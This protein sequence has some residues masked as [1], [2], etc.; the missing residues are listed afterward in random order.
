MIYASIVIYKHS[1]EELEPTLNS[2]FASDSVTKVILVD[3]DKSTWAKDFL[4]PKIIYIKSPSNNGFGFGHNLA[5]KEFA[6]QSDYFLICNPDIIYNFED[7]ENF[8]NFVKTRP[9]GLFLP[10]IIYPNGEDQFGARL[11]PSP[12]NLFARRFSKKLA[13][14]LDQQYLL[15]HY[16]IDKPTF[17]PYLSGCFML[18]KSEVLIAIDGFDE[19]FFMYMEDIDISRRCAEKFG[20]LYCPQFSITHVHEQASYKNR[21]LLKAHLQSAILYFNKWGWLY[22]SSRTRLNNQC[23]NALAKK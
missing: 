8:F 2:L 20:N 17:V 15:K 5:I 19:L 10:K 23:V 9:E 18:F 22:D 1:L 6:G 12:M 3:N 4:H 11:L 7:F 21:K 13:L 16:I 14:Q